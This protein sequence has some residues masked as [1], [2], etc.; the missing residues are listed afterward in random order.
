[1]GNGPQRRQRHP[2]CRVDIESFLIACECLRPADVVP[3]DFDGQPTG[4]PLV[5]CRPA[6]A[7]SF[8]DSGGKL[9]EF[10]AMLPNTPRPALGIVNATRWKTH[11]CAVVPLATD[12]GQAGGLT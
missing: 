6:A 4:E 11:P 12:R 5:L 2:A 1:M 3:L 7:V 10:L 9:L 8:L